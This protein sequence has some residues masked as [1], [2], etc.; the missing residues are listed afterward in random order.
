MDYDNERKKLI[1]SKLKNK[2]QMNN[3]RQEIDEDLQSEPEDQDFIQNSTLPHS[4]TM[5]KEQFHVEK[6]RLAKP[7]RKTIL[8]KIRKL[9]TLQLN[10]I[11]SQT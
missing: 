4:G 7:S 6:P 1:F 2:Q 3:A 9:K 5:K 8:P 10:S 11:D